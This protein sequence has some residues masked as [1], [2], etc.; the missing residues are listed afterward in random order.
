MY[1]IVKIKFEPLT[2]E[3]NQTIKQIEDFLNDLHMN[4]QIL[5]GWVLEE[6]HPFFVA[7][8]TTTASNA[9]DKRFYNVYLQEKASNWKISIETVCNDALATDHCNC[10]SHRFLVMH[11]DMDYCSSPVLCGDCGKEI[12]LVYLPHLFDEQEHYSILNWQSIYHSVENL[13]RNSLS[14]RFFKRQLT[15]HASQLNQRG[16]EIREELEKKTE[17]PVYMFLKNPI[18]G[19]YQAEKNNRNLSCCPKCSGSF[20]FL[21]NAPVDKVCDTCR[22]AFYHYPNEIAF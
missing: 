15:D 9:L 22:L 19:L 5:T 6:R 17:I 18:G 1:Q 7:T 8:V 4:G 21:E 14:D 16:Q 12:P 13:W 20:R 10:A 11:A 3:K 2:V